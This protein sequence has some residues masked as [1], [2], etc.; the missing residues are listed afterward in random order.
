[1]LEE[2]GISEDEL[3]GKKKKELERMAETVLTQ[4]TE[5]ISDP[6]ETE[7]K[8]EAK[9][10]Q[11]L[12]VGPGDEGWHEFVMAQLRDT[13]KRD[14]YPTLEGLRR[15]TEG[16]I[17]PIIEREITHLTPPSE[18]NRFT[19]TVALR[20]V[21]QRI[22]PPDGF[23]STQ[24]VDMDAADAGLLNVDDDLFAKHPTAVALSRAEARI[25][26]RVLHLRGIAAEERAENASG[27][28]EAVNRGGI[29]DVQCKAIETL[30]KRKGI[31]TQKFAE[32]QGV[33]KILEMTAQAAS[34]AIQKLNE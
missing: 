17:G 20:L 19:A 3:K 11:V 12:M 25:L 5:Y 4:P 13:E 6:T 21:I 33:S 26:R 8:S 10:D 15:L 29:S 1:M 31:D 24:L 27:F 2:C 9:S 34:K 32:E 18:I 22:S 23:V 30:C 28:A 7:A 16:L 14:G